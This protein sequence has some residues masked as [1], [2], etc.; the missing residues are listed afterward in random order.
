MIMRS[1]VH[2]HVGDGTVASSPYRLPPPPTRKECMKTWIVEEKPGDEA[3]GTALVQGTARQAG[4]LS[5]NHVYMICD[6]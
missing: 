1:T 3:N 4:T 6:S 2:V 5:D